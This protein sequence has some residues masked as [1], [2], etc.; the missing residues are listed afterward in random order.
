MSN[1][2]KNVLLVIISEMCLWYLVHKS[3]Q[4]TNSFPLI[5]CLF[6]HV[7]ICTGLTLTNITCDT[8]HI[9]VW[10]VPAS[11][12]RWGHQGETW[13]SLSWRCLC[14]S[15]EIRWHEK[16]RCYLVYTLTSTLCCGCNKDT[17]IVQIPI[18]LWPARPLGCGQPIFT[19]VYVALWGSVRLYDQS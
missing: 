7:S 19:Q 4:L 13:Q 12:W 16:Q 10:F 8:H 2:N 15:L 14:L 11:G 3:C 18:T 6:L 1:T 17:Q 9:G 5:W